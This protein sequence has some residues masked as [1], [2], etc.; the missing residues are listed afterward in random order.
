MSRTHSKLHI[1]IRVIVTEPMTV[2]EARQRLART[3]RTGIVQKGIELAW[4]DWR[5]PT[6]ARRT[7]GGT[8]LGDD[9]LDALREFYAAIHHDQTKTRVEVIDAG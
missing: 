3:V 9:A 7:R 1:K 6:T 4:I 2:G 5:D 8:Y